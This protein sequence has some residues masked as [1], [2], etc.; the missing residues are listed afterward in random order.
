MKK[1]EKHLARR[2]FINKREYRLSIVEIERD[3]EG[4]IRTLKVM[5]FVKEEAGVTYHDSNLSF[6]RCFDG[7]W[8]LEEG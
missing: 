8:K 6:V 1:K 7:L 4:N 2:I 3:E 5:P